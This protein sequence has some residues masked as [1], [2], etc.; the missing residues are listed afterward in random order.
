MSNH[1]FK[2]TAHFVKNPLGIIGL[3]LV[4]VYGISTLAFSLQTFDGWHLSVLLIFNVVYPVFS[5]CVLYVLITRHHEKLYSPL[6]FQNA[7][8]FEN[9]VKLKLQ[10][11]EREIDATVA[12]ELRKKMQELDKETKREMLILKCSTSVDMGDFTGAN[13]WVDEALELRE[14]PVAL[15]WKAYIL[16]KDHKI[17]EALR[18][19]DRAIELGSDEPRAIHFYNR[20][21][22]K[23]QLEY[24]LDEIVCDLRRALQLDPKLIKE[25]RR[26]EDL[27]AVH[28]TSEFKELV[29]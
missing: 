19:L 11:V 13:K 15:A 18:Y 24:A 5:L 6:D 27:F 17:E 4:S 1:L 25:A 8:S 10:K 21:C 28:V 9:L 12:A 29:A 20:A 26:D 14:E 3:L 23:T 7:E 16:R 2:S 22:Y